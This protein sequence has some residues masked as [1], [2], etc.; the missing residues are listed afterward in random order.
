MLGSYPG[1]QELAGPYWEEITLQY[2]APQRH[3]HNLQHLR[4]LL[5]QLL[6]VRT[7]VRDWDTLLFSMYYHDIVYDPLRQDNEAQSALI[8]SERLERLGVPATAIQRCAAQIAA[9]AAHS[10]SADSDT[11]YFTDADLS[12]LGQDPE[13]YEQYY[14]AVRLEYDCY[15]DHIYIPGLKKVLE[16]FLAMRRIFKTGYFYSRLEF[17]ARDN[18]ARELAYLQG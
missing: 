16:H 12:V 14:K 7:A 6:Q 2:T 10:P 1:H 3:Y 17:Q 18:I 5:E 4:Q 9:T 13:V 11:D 8:A 15:P